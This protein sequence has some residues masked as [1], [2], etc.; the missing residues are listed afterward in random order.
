[1][2]GSVQMGK[3]IFQEGK[4]RRNKTERED[5]EEKKETRIERKKKRENKYDTIEQ[6]GVL[7]RQRLKERE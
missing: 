7:D 2:H 4:S 5:R 3:V 1:M 6:K